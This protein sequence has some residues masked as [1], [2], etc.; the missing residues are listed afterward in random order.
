MRLDDQLALQDAA[1]LQV[2][3]WKDGER[4]RSA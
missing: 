2:T 1:L 4:R 3:A